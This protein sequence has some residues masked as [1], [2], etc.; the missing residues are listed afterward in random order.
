M[1]DLNE[2]KF[3]GLF[4]PLDDE[5]T[6]TKYIEK[7]KSIEPVKGAF[8]KVNNIYKKCKLNGIITKIDEDQ[9]YQNKLNFFMTCMLAPAFFIQSS[10]VLFRIKFKNSSTIIG[11]CGFILAVC[12]SSFKIYRF[13]REMDIKYTPLWLKSTGKLEKNKNII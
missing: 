2:N 12:F 7:Y 1:T 9:E 8:K 6:V 11:T 5:I 13:N 4:G 3:K 10:S